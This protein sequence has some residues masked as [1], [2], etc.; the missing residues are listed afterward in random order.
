MLSLIKKSLFIIVYN[1]NSEILRNI[2]KVELRYF[3]QQ[4]FMKRFSKMKY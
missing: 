4:H 3:S 2:I 1:L